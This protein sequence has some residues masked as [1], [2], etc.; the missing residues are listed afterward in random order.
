MGHSTPNRTNLN[1]DLLDFFH[2]LPTCNACYRILKSKELT[3]KSALVA[4]LDRSKVQ[5]KRN[6]PSTWSHLTTYMSRS[7]QRIFL[8]LT[9]FE[10]ISPA[11]SEKR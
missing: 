1:F 11:D 10:S 7:S 6:S 4:K 8:I 9:L 2:F 5:K 3:S